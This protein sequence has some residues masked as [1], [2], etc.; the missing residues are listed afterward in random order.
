MQPEPYHDHDAVRLKRDLQNAR[1]EEGK[2]V[3]VS[4]NTGGVIMQSYPDASGKH[5]YLVEFSAET[6]SN[7]YEFV[8]E[9]LGH[10]DLELVKRINSLVNEPI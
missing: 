6:D 10:D 4:K 7:F 2:L 3:Q 9:E 8:L 1:T 5:K